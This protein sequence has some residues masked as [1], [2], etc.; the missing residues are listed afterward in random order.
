VS[1][2]YRGGEFYGETPISVHCRRHFLWSHG[3]RQIE[4]QELARL[5]PV[6][7]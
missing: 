2:K 7:A 4:I 6:D 5:L 3:V 1:E